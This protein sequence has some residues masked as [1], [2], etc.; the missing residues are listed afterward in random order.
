MEKPDTIIKSAQNKN[1]GL[2]EQEFIRLTKELKEGK[3]ALFEKIFLSHFE[4]CQQFLVVKYSVS[5]EVAYDITMDTLIQFRQRILLDKVS[6]G[7]LRYLFTMMASQNLIKRQQKSK[8]P[9]FNL[10]Y[11]EGPPPKGEEVFD[12]LSYAWDSLETESKSILEA[13]YYKKTPLVKIANRLGISDAAM[14][15]KKQ[16]SLEKLRGLFMTKYQSEK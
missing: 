16:R 2:S 13:F 7:N 14:R 12:A 9:D 15:K 10:F 6:Y 8:R 11:L 5:T 3:E 4:K 1:F